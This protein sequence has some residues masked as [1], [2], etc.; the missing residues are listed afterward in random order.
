MTSKSAFVLSRTQPNPFAMAAQTATEPRTYNEYTVRWVCAL[1]KEQTAA[2]A[3]LDLR[4]A[5]LP[6]PPN[7]PNTYTLGSLG[8][9]NV[10]IACLSKGKI[11]I[12]PAAT[13][14]A[15]MIST[16]PSIKLSMRLMNVK[17]LMVAERKFLPSKP[18]PEQISLQ[19]HAIYQISKRSLREVHYWRSVLVR[20]TCPGCRDL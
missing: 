3:M 12:N 15:W 19:L 20:K 10:V 5:D 8:K 11:G 9:H 1:P 14:A 13:V 4:H 17:H 6:K 2:T 7:D 16:F 18:K